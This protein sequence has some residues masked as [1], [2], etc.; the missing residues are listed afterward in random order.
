MLN[1]KLQLASAVVEKQRQLMKYVLLLI[2]ISFNSFGVEPWQQAGGMISFTLPFQRDYK[3]Y[4]NV[5]KQLFNV[6]RI[7]NS[8]EICP[9]ISRTVFKIYENIVSKNNLKRFISEGPGLDLRLNCVTLRPMSMGT[10]A[11]AGNRVVLSVYDLHF[12]E[13]EDDIAFAISHEISHALLGHVNRS[14]DD[15]NSGPS[16]LQD[17]QDADK[18]A[19]KLMINA[20]YNPLGGIRFLRNLGTGYKIYKRFFGFV[21]HDEISNHGTVESRVLGIKQAMDSVNYKPR[22]TFISTSNDLQAFKKEYSTL[23]EQ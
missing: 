17:E 20:G 4:L 8:A 11:M 1:L 18:F 3:N 13:A 5:Q 6:R 10:R 21:V 23:N 7:Y 14:A 9:D 15:S 16:I 19:V 2:F 22:F 12:A